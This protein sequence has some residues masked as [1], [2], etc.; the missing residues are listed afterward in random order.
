[1]AA[2]SWCFTDNNYTGFPPEMTDKMRYMV[3]QCELGEET[4]TPHLQGYIEFLEPVRM[5][6]KFLPRA[7]W[8]KKIATREDARK[9][10]MKDDT[11]DEILEHPGPFEFGTW[12]TCQGQRTD[13]IEFNNF[14]KIE[15]PTEYE[16][17]ERFPN[18]VFNNLRY[19]QHVQRVMRNKFDRRDPNNPPIIT[20]YYGPSGAGKTR[21]AFEELGPECYI[22]TST[23]KEWW[24]G[25]EGQKQVLI[26]EADKGFLKLCDFL[27]ILDRYPVIVNVKGGDC[28]FNPTHITLTA[29]KHPAFWY[30][31]CDKMELAGLC[32]RINKIVPIGVTPSLAEAHEM[33]ARQLMI[34]Y[35]EGFSR[36][37]ED[38]KS[39]L[40]DIHG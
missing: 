24:Q 12:D 15:K 26:D 18:M 38:D 28:Q 37:S 40:L 3:F 22:K 33:M 7:H 9:Y 20:C 19:V 35:P 34:E 32:R 8:E 27:H 11:R 30:P 23:T 16:I 4:G 2:R 21:R 36:E 39:D 13:L 6:K 29:N 10:C 1:M 25:Y 5:P 31:N 14:I 17:L